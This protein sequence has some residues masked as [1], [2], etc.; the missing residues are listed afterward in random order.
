M[1]RITGRVVVKSS[2]AL[3]STG[4]VY[5]VGRRARGQAE[6]VLLDV[7]VNM[8]DTAITI[9]EHLA[10]MDLRDQ[11]SVV[12]PT[13][14][15]LA[16]AIRPAQA[17]VLIATRLRA[18]RA[19]T[20]LLQLQP[21]TCK[22]RFDTSEYATF[23]DD[24]ATDMVNAPCDGCGGMC[25]C[26][27]RFLNRNRDG[28]STYMGLVAMPDGIFKEHKDG[29][30][31][32]VNATEQIFDESLYDAPMAIVPSDVFPHVATR[33]SAEMRAALP[34]VQAMLREA[35]EDAPV[36]V[37]PDEVRAGDWVA[38]VDARCKDEDCRDCHHVLHVLAV[39]H[40]DHGLVVSADDIPCAF[41]IPVDTV[42]A[43]VHGPHW[44]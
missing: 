28:V 37:D 31:H 21:A 15:F 5:T 32:K 24:L 22:G 6:L 40:D 43:S 26:G 36:V 39:H 4:V 42:A 38:R 12:H 19:S 18:L 30:R 29:S 35:A 11:S 9:V 23:C 7:P 27:G 33:G 34:L 10:Y 41:R 14:V 44:A 16:T 13:S 25:G 17:R 20:R 3:S 2:F 1:P 8:K